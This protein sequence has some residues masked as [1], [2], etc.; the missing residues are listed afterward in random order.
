MQ[1][2]TNERAE[3]DEIVLAL[4]TTKEPFNDPIARQALAYGIDQNQMADI[5][6]Q[7]AMPGAWGMFSR[8]L[9]RTTSRPRRPATR[10]TTWRRPRR[11]VAEY[12]QKH[13]K[14]L[15][16]TMLVGADPDSLAVMQAYQAEMAELRRQDEHHV[17]RD[18]PAHQPGHRE[19]RLPGRRSSACGRRR[20]PIRATC[21]SPPR[22]TPTASRSTTRASTTRASPPPSTPSGR[23]AIRKERID[24]MKKRPAGAWPRTCRSS[25]SPTS[26]RVRLRQQR[27]RLHGAGVPGHRRPRL[28]PL[29]DDAVLHLRVARPELRR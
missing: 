23:R 18:D 21:S 29:P 28:Q 14:P 16:F 15:E 22:R 5:A 3:T 10:P 20:R 7:G 17:G 27:P 26:E 24:A 11:L 25:S 19:R 13:G 8:E 1:R 12:E 6:Y 2:L 9:A 4:N